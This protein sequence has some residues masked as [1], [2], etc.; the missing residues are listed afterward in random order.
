MFVEVALCLVDDATPPTV[1][2]MVDTQVNETARFT[3]VFKA[4]A[5]IV[6]RAIQIGKMRFEVLCRQQFTSN[7][8]EMAK[9]EGRQ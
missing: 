5:T 7:G 2:A 3:S 1:S 9:I 4:V 6:L 8:S